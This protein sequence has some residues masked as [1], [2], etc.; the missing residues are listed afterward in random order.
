MVSIPTPIRTIL[1][2]VKQGSI[3]AAR[4]AERHALEAVD[5]VV[6]T[7]VTDRLGLRRRHFERAFHSGSWSGD[8]ESRSGDGSSLA[9]TESLRAALPG[10]LQRLE[11]TTMLDVPCGDWAWMSQVDLPVDHYIGGDI[12]ADLVAE[13]AGA[14]GDDTHE[15]RVIDL[16]VDD[17]PDADL[18]LCR[19]AW[20]HFSNADI[21]RAIGQ[22][23][24][25][26]ITYLA[27]TT[28][29]ATERNT[30]QPTGRDWRHL[31]L[32]IPPFSFPEPLERVVDD[33]NR[34]DQI[35]AVWRV[36]DLPEPP[37]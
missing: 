18:L 11:V 28:F 35:I 16:C 20:I 31:N 26:S 1:S 32:E 34:P 25:A 22:I 21:G 14:H 7:T 3:T 4:R 23:R 33:F 5:A 27:T 30:D 19:D 12:V 17:L 6:P 8:G 13:T 36:A 29:A 2:Q 15:F 37:T 9:A 24:A 10:L